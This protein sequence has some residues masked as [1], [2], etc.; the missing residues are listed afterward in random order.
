MNATSTFE[1]M[2]ARFP[3]GGVIIYLA[4]ISVLGFTAWQG[5][6]DL[7]DRRTAVASGMALLVQL[8]SR[9]SP[10]IRQGGTPGQNDPTGSPFLE[11]ETITVAGAAL[12]QRVAGAV[13]KYGGDI[14]SSQV[15]L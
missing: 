10:T 7:L 1:R 9:R 6:V 13:T 12:L 11:G 2:L 8:E 15:D 3:I 14:M 5:V 4:V